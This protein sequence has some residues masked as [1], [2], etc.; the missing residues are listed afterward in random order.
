MQNF[1]F[2]FST[3]LEFGRPNYELPKSVFQPQIS[4]TSTLAPKKFSVAK[5]MFKVNNP[6][7]KASRKIIKK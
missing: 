2:S 5:Y 7:T 4:S 3:F 6:N 1:D